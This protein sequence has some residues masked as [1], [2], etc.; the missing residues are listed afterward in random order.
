MYKG[1][2]LGVPLIG[3]GYYT[4]SGTIVGYSPTPLSF[5]SALS[6]SGKPVTILGNEI[7]TAGLAYP[8]TQPLLEKDVLGG[9]ILWTQAIASVEQW[10]LNN[11][12]GGNLYLSGMDGSFSKYNSAGMQIWTTNY[13]SP[14]V[15]GLA[16]VSGDHVV[17]FADNTIALLQADPGSTAPIAHLSRKVG[18]GT[19]ATGFRF[20]ASG[21]PGCVY[22]VFWSTNLT[23]WQS[24]GYVTNNTGDMQVVDPDATNHLQKF[25]RFS[26]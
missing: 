24:M 4:S 22:E 5:T 3:R 12:G 7:Y 11:D 17:Q 26:P 9:G 2:S 23:S 15:L 18:D 6:I 13:A 10:I 1:L 16:D 25:Y 19:S 14:A 20:S 8:G 21:S